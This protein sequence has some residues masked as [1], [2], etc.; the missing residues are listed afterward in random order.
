MNNNKLKNKIAEMNNIQLH[1][2]KMLISKELFNL[3][4]Q[5]AL[6]DLKNTSRFSILKKDIARIE[7]EF[8]RRLLK[9]DKL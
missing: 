1:E 4:F 5:K 6:G 3:R 9:G 8:S 2:E 7:T